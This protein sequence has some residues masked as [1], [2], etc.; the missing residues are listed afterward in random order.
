MGYVRVRLRSYQLTHLR[1]LEAE[2]IDI[3]RELAAER[4]RPVLLFSGGKDSVLLLH[5][6]LKSFRPAR[7]PFPIMPSTPGTISRRRS[8]SAIARW[9]R[10]TSG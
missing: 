4:E 6:A 8:S 1:T 9:P 5:L 3:F 7:F 10:S 2:A